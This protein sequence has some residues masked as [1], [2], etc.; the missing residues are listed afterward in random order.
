[1]PRRNLIVSSSTKKRLILPN[2]V[3]R[4]DASK[5]IRSNIILEIG[6]KLPHPSGD[7][8]GRAFYH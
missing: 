5:A 7:I 8:E 1:M 4:K 6:T 3:V 2:L